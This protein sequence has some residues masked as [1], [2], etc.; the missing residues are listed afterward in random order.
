MNRLDIGSF[1]LWAGDFR[2]RTVS[3]RGG[4]GDWDGGRSLGGA[5]DGGGTGCFGVADEDGGTEELEGRRTALTVTRGLLNV[6][7]G[8]GRRLLVVVLGST[9]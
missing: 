3:A 8:A 1:L 7:G 9:R 4:G 6:D 5:V 2:G